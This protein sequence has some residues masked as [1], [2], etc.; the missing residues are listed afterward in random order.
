MKILAVDTASKS[1][2]T[3]VVSEEGV[4]AEITQVTGET[5]AKHLMGMI[6]NAVQL[7]GLAPSDLDGY[8]VTIGPGSFTGLRIGISTV[9][10]LSAASGKPVAGI[11]SL[12]AL[13]ALFSF[14][15]PWVC[16][17]LDARR[18]E[19][20][21][22]LYQFGNSQLIHKTSERALSAAEAVAVIKAP[23]LFVGDGSVVY[24]DTIQEIIGNRAIFAPDFQNHINAAA[25]GRLGM[26]KFNTREIQPAENLVPFYLR[27]SDAQ[28]ASASTRTP[29]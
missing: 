2:S 27:K 29:V 8:A 4:L 15:S 24:R 28:I 5:H 7:S 18:G 11:S 26:E 19:V 21:S 25:V 1:C 10:G 12:D 20:Y 13:A 23:C 16:A 22:S 14:A 6:D 9:K 17:M 3:A